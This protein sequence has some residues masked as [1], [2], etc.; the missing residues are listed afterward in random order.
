MR[1]SYTFLHILV[2]INQVIELVAV[3]GL[4]AVQQYPIDPCADI[5]LSSI[6]NAII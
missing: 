2:F 6:S 5:Q 3:A 1:R 4:V